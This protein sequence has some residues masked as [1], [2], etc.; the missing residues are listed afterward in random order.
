[1]HKV[2]GK[3]K[4]RYASK[5]HL[6]EALYHGV[7]HVGV[8]VTGSV[9]VAKAEDAL[10]DGQLCGGGVEASD[11][12][13]VVD[14]HAG[15]DDVAATVD[16]AGN[17]GHLE[18]TRELILVLDARL[19]VNE[20]ALIGKAHIGADED[21]IGDGLAKDLDAEDVGDDL[22]GLTL[23]IRV[24]EGD[25]I[26][27][28]NDVAEGREA[29][30]D[31]LD[32]HGIGQGVAQVLQLLVRRG[33]GHEQALAVAGGEAA[34][35]A[36]AGNGGAHDGDDVLQLGLEDAV[37]VFAGALGNEGIRVCECGKDTNPAGRVLASRLL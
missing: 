26:V 10:N 11:G 29:L 4:T 25:V 20:A 5:L 36:R 33:R 35:D 7:L 12:Q 23:E 9:A 27:G 14:D 34:D 6:V 31:A 19:G 15:A 18:E 1:M 3:S 8:D 32:T 37:K 28:G 21:V 30:L 22:L 13:P 17:E 24:D 16:G 2:T